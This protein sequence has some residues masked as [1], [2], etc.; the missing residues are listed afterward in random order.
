VHRLPTT[1]PETWSITLAGCPNLIGM[2]EHGLFWGTTNIKTNDARIGVG[3]MDVLHRASRCQDREVAIALIA[4]APRCG[5]HTYWLAD[6]SGATEL[7]C[8]A[9]RHERRDCTDVPLV[10]TNHCLAPCIAELAAE[11]V[12]SSSARRLRRATDA[13]AHGPVSIDDIRRLFADR[14]DGVDSISRLP[15]DGT[16]TTTNAC[17]IA[18]PQRR[19]LLCC[20]GPA[21]RGQWRHLRFQGS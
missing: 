1:G 12:S 6:S 16:D 14:S 5:A 8:S 10:Q 18:R 13:L 17:I 9:T 2:N 3:Y 20:R 11:P 7:E 21:D 19:E 15:E 4:D